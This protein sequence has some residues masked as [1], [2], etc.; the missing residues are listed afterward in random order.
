VS[1]KFLKSTIS[2][3]LNNSDIKVKEKEYMFKKAYNSF[4]KNNNYSINDIYIFLQKELNNIKTADRVTGI[5]EAFNMS[6]KSYNNPYNKKRNTQTVDD[7]DKELLTPGDAAKDSIGG[8]RARDGSG[9]S[10]PHDALPEDE[11]DDNQSRKE[12]PTSEHTLLDDNYSFHGRMRDG[13]NE[14]IAA[15]DN[16]FTEAPSGMTSPLA[17]PIAPLSRINPKDEN[18]TTEQ[19]LDKNRTFNNVRKKSPKDIYDVALKRLGL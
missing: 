17:A 9:M 16:V 4:S 15:R 11:Q 1:N 2:F 6:P 3:V 14:D 18:T 12:I 19:K 5:P 7:D 8:S 13:Q 10:F